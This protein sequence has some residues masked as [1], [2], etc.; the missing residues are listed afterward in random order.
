MPEPPRAEISAAQ[1]EAREAGLAV[2]L[3]DAVRPEVDRWLARA[4]EQDVAARLWRRDD[5][6][7]GPSGTPEVADRLGWLAAPEASRRAVAEVESFV[8][9]CRADGLEDAV[10]LGMGGSSLAPEVVRRSLAATGGPGRPALRLH[11][12]DSVDPDAVRSVE[13][14]LRLERTLFVVSTKSGGTVETQSLARHFLAR[15]EQALGPGAAGAHFAAITDPG[16]SLVE[17]AERRHFRRIFLGDPEIG[18]RFSALSVFGTIPAALA[19]LELGAL[20]EAADEGARLCAPDRTGAANPGV[21]LGTV[22]G[23]LALGGRDKLGLLIDE[24]LESLGLWLEQ[25][26]AE[27]TGKDGCGIVPVVG[28]AAAEVPAAAPATDRVWLAIGPE[29]GPAAAHAAH[30]RESGQP[31]LVLAAREP[32]DLGRVCF[33]AELAVAVAGWVLGVNPFDQPNVQD[34]K[35]RT[36]AVLERRGGGTANEPATAAVGLATVHSLLAGLR[37]PEYLALMAFAAPSERLERAGEQLRAAIAAS[38]GAAVTFG[39]GPRFLHSTGQLHKGGPRTGRFLQLVR[40]PA[41]PDL[42]IPE[43]GHGFGELLAAQA[44]GD[45]E[46]LRATG[47]PAERIVLA[48]DPAA[49]L[50]ELAGALEARAGP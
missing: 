7:W 11:V 41:D 32:A 44:D 24:P 47:R 25:L 1:A 9:E 31:A 34:T 14:T 10:V 6:L 36:Q 26:V 28:E 18:G 27:S 30:L 13:R 4:V 49:A 39:L 15:A 42:P 37:P 33:V 22:L 50:E 5:T 40:A 45:L 29:D 46:A 20:L 21:H 17:L 12:L 16:S 2:D 48:G 35:T 19:G 43:A 38:T 8:E 3:P 23:A